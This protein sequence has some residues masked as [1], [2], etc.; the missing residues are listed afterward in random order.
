MQGYG[1]EEDRRNRII[2]RIIIG[3]IVAAVLAWV[4]YLLFHN[5]TEKKTVNQFLAEINAHD[6]KAAYAKWCNAANPCP[7][8]DYGR[9]LQDWG[10][11]KKV[12]S[13]WKVASVESCK[14]FVTVN[15]QAAGA[16]LQSLGVQRGT[17]TLMYAPAPECQEMQWHWKAFFH[18]IFGGS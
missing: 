10:P 3:A 11:Q 7:Y 5:Y 9:F 4:F 17:R 16:E 15:V 6:Y 12:S 8:Y 2:K 18:R 1:V 14:S 13:P